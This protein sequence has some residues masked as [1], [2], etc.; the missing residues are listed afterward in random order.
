MSQKYLAS[1][2]ADLERRV[3]ADFDRMWRECIEPAIK[4][5]YN[6]GLADG[7]RGTAAH[8]TTNKSRRR[9]LGTRSE[10]HWVDASG[11]ATMPRRP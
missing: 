9:R 8:T 6:N 4:T 3:H 5:S 10:T 11:G 2:K 7:Q 1:I